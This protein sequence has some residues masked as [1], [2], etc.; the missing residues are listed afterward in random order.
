MKLVA[1]KGKLIDDITTPARVPCLFSYS[2]ISI[3]LTRKASKQTK[4]EGMKVPVYAP[5]PR[6]PL[7][8]PAYCHVKTLA[9]VVELKQM[10]RRVVQ[11][12]L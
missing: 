6:S 12:C 5:N 11:A 2:Y 3:K 4:V 10:S 7:V 1:G 8:S 9:G